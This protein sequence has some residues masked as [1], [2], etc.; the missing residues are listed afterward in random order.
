MWQLCQIV[1]EILPEAGIRLL[2]YVWLNIFANYQIVLLA[3]D[4]LNYVM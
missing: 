1:E 4:R 3:C 2:R